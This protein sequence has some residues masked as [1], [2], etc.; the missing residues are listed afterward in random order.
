M[1]PPATGDPLVDAELTRAFNRGDTW[2]VQDILQRHGAS[3]RRGAPAAR[4]ALEAFNARVEAISE[5]S[6]PFP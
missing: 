6:P 1:D 5:G 4:A 2:G 3:G